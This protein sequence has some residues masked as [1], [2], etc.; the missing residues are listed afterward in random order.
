[1]AILAGNADIS[2]MQTG[3]EIN[4]NVYPKVND[5]EIST[6][7]IIYI[8]PKKRFFRVEFTV[9]PTGETIRESFTAYGPRATSDSR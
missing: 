3:D 9:I 8:D 6:G 1:M 7:R 5:A 2:V 4:L